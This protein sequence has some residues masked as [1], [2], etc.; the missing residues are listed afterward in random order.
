MNKIGNNILQ[1]RPEIY[2]V[3]NSVFNQQVVN[4]I[5]KRI[6]ACPFLQQSQAAQIVFLNNKAQ[7]HLYLEEKKGLNIIRLMI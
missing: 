5:N 6:L 2:P 4:Q 7:I 3:S 1:Y